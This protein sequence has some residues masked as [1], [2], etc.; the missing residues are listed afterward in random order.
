MISA[1]SGSNASALLALFDRSQ[2]DTASRPTQTVPPPHP[3]PLPQGTGASAQSLFEALVD[4]GQDS[5]TGA[6][7]APLDDFLSNLFAA[8]DRDGDGTLNQSELKSALSG[9]TSTSSDDA[10]PTHSA[11]APSLYES[12]FNAIASDDGSGAGTTRKDDLSQKFLSP[13]KA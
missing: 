10:T 4:V 1:V 8:L 13:L 2:T 7:K 6:Q 9:L 5:T 3:P 12:L 11:T